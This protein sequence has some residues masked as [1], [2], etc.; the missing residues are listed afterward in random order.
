[1]ASYLATVQIGR[2]ELVELRRRRPVTIA[3][4]SALRPRLDDAFGRQAEMIAFFGKTFGDYPFAGYAVVVTEDELEIPLESQ[5]LSTFG[6]NLLQRRLGRGPAGR[7]RAVAPVVRQQRDPDGLEGH[8]AARGLRL[9]L[10]VAVV[11]GVRKREL[12]RARGRALGATR[13]T[14][15]RTCCWPT[16]VRTLMFD[17]RVYKRG[18]LFLHALR[19]A[20]GDDAFFEMMRGWVAEHAYGH[21]TTEQFVDWAADQISADVTGLAQAWLHEKSLPP[22]PPRLTS[23]STDETTATQPTRPSSRL[24]PTS[25]RRHCV[26]RRGRSEQDGRLVGARQPEAPRIDR[27]ARGPRLHDGLLAHPGDRGLLGTARGL[28][29]VQE[30]PGD[31]G[32]AFVG[33]PLDVDAD[34]GAE[35]HGDDE[36][37]RRPA[38]AHVDVVQPG[39]ERVVRG[40]R[41]RTVGTGVRPAAAGG[42]RGGRR[43]R[44]ARRHRRGGADDGDARASVQPPSSARRSAVATA[45]GTPPRPRRPRSRP[46]LAGARLGEQLLGQ[47]WRRGGRRGAAGTSSA[48]DAAERRRRRRRR[49]LTRGGTAG[50]WPTCAPRG[51]APGRRRPPVSAGRSTRSRT[52]RQS[53]WAPARTSSSADACAAGVKGGSAASASRRASSAAYRGSSIVASRLARA[54]P[55]L[56]IEPVLQRARLVAELGEPLRLHLGVAHLA[57]PRAEPLQLAP[58]RLAPRWRRR[59]GR[60]TPACSAVAGRPPAG[61]APSRRRPRGPAGRARAPGRRAREGARAAGPRR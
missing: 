40:G 42:D 47:R 29:R 3:I 5:G 27:Q 49:G 50:A 31:L 38:D 16:P 1:M 37:A 17:D 9:L 12:P 44:G 24:R 56:A 35:A 18:A 33:G 15:T 21:V 60:T 20:G 45:W 61:R 13:R 58:E 25:L 19:L 8:L 11:G 32:E 28:E 4:P 34:R 57:Q 30:H 59:P 10:G 23:G 52:R 51:D 39:Q 14:S 7:A 36:D 2:Y 48:V 54:V 41:S 46:R 55:V 22:L 53:L 6:S 26:V 43:P